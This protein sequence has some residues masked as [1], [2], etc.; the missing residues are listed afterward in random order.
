MLCKIEKE[1][2]IPALSRPLFFHFYSSY[3]SFLLCIC[4]IVSFYYINFEFEIHFFFVMWPGGSASDSGL[5]GSG[6]GPHWQQSIVSLSKTHNPQ[7]YW[8]DWK[9][10][11]W[12]IETHYK[13]IFCVAGDKVGFSHDTAQWASPRLTAEVA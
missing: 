1:D 12:Y 9:I 3:F 8:H 2:Y 4:F 6:F 13:Q 5:R 7:Q 10:V 11:D